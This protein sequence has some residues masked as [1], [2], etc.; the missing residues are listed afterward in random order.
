M[1]LKR[2]NVAAPQEA[3]VRVFLSYSHDSSAHEQ[4]VLE[5]ANR[6]RADGIDAW[7]DRYEANPPQGWPRWMQEQI[8]KARYILL[9]C[10]ETYMRRFEGKEE[11]GKGKGPTWEGLLAMQ[12]LYDAGT[13]NEKLIPVLLDSG[14][15]A[16]IPLALRPF[17]YHRLPAGYE[18]LFLYLSGQPEVTP[19]PVGPL[20]R[21]PMGSSPLP[22]KPEPTRSGGL[23][24]GVLG[25][26]KESWARATHAEIRP[27]IMG[28]KTAQL[29][30]D[31]A[32]DRFVP[33]GSRALATKDASRG[34]HHWQ[35][36][37]G[38]SELGWRPDGEVRAG[39]WVE[40]SPDGADFEVHALIDADGDGR[41]AEYVVSR[42]TDAK[43]VTTPEYL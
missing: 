6:L 19:P 33:C 13:I 7:I 16:H 40:V 23:L 24:P 11:A 21:T 22:L 31:A 2:E 3:P 42:H 39:Y 28:I 5:L 30:F 35:G 10:T 18:S 15:E 20:R 29:A 27:N 37:S 41:M 4:A 17:T 43:L 12:V 32:Y 34:L 36:G 25:R 1:D 8:E 9:V 26:F 38:W 14:S